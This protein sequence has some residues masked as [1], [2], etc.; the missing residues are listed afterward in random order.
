M[1]AHYRWTDKVDAD[2]G[3][4]GRARR[5]P[6]SS[7][8]AI[9]AVQRDWAR[10]A[11]HPRLTAGQGAHRVGAVRPGP[12]RQ[13]YKRALDVFLVVLS[14]PVVLP[15]I[16]L[17]AL[18]NMA[19][20]NMP[21]YTQPRL[22]RDG[23]VFR[24]WKLR[25]MVADADSKLAEVLAR[26]PALQMEWDHKQKLRND[27]RITAVGR[28]LRMTSLDELPQLWNVLRGDMSLVGPR[29]M[30]PEQRALY[31]GDAY[32]RL[33]P[34]LTCTWQ[35]SERND[36]CFAE[37][38]R[39]DAEYEADVSLAHDIGLILATFAVVTRGTGH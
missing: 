8:T 11:A 35:V 5:I 36:S 25:T 12:Y 31:P 24:M 3:A 26:D 1:T 6:A 16:L 14:L 29:P 28:Y 17:L 15:L 4:H 30:L 39:Y 37:R 7:A 13:H 23:Q 18:C 33:R 38:A 9:S 32:F 2:T 27:P 20:G 22:G 34:G 21:F 10:A 19:T